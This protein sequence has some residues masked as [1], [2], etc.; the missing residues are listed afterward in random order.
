MAPKFREAPEAMELYGVRVEK[1]LSRTS[2]VVSEKVMEVNSLWAEE[3]C[4]N[5]SSRRKFLSLVFVGCCLGL[6]WL[7]SDCMPANNAWKEQ[8]ETHPAAYE[9]LVKYT[10]AASSAT[11]TPTGVLEVFQVYQPVLTPQGATDETVLSDGQENT[12]SIAP[13]SSSSCEVL[14][15]DHIFAY[16]YGIPFVGMCATYKCSL[17]D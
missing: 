16:S 15:M 2:D 11:P 3:D 6:G 8:P 5:F 7:L 14:L 1:Q 12:T 10:A 13:A 4:R 17:F 9:H